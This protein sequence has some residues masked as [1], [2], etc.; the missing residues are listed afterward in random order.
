MEIA[1]VDDLPEDRAWLSV[2]L[3]DYMRAHGPEYRLT[4]FGS[5]EDFLAALEHTRFDIVFMDIYM[6]G[7]T[8]IETA[9]ALR[10][11][12]MDC[13]LVFLTSSEDFLREGYALNPCHYLVKPTDDAAFAQAME[14]CRVTVRVETPTLE[15]VSGGLPV[16]LDTTKILY[17]DVDGRNTA[18]HMDD[19]VVS[20][21]GS[22]SKVTAPLAADRRF[23]LCIQGVLANMDFIVG[24]EDSV[25]LLKNGERLPIALRQKRGVI[26]AYRAYLFERMGGGA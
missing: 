11:R 10:R 5:G 17:V 14:N 3:G 24:P 6:G 18:V 16:H 15:V 9:A 8:G 1:V 7:M 25:F 2:K 26:Q 13:K 20:A 22:F 4:A 19:R 12:D 23:L 21:V